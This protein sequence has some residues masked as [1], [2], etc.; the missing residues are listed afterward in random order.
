MS[1]IH[2]L[3]LGRSSVSKEYRQ[4]REDHHGEEL[5]LPVL[6]RFKPERRAAHK[7]PQA[8]PRLAMLETLL[9]VLRQA[10][11]TVKQKRNGKKGKQGQGER[12]LV[13]AQHDAAVPDRPRCVRLVTRL[14]W[15]AV[16]VF[17]PAFR[18]LRF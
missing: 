8:D 12:P 1:G 2:G 10:G 9:V 6:K 7:S 5:A 16:D 17:G 15:I 14:A 3:R 13:D 4:D 11:E 18:V